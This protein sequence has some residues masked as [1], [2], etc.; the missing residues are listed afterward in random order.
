VR[1]AGAVLGRL[2][3]GWETE[4]L[5]ILG[6]GVGE[7]ETRMGQF[8]NTTLVALRWECDDAT[9]EPQL[10]YEGCVAMLPWLVKCRHLK[11]AAL[12]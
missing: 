8:H 1:G 3:R 9:K 7:L 4:G 11:A 10:C 12:Q 2:C 6:G 5:M